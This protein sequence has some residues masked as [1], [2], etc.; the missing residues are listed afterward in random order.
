MAARLPGHKVFQHWNK[1]NRDAG[2]HK[3]PH[4]YRQIE[5][6]YKKEYI[7]CQYLVIQRPWNNLARRS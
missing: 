1:R 5:F 4:P 3:G 2:G 6:I 7:L